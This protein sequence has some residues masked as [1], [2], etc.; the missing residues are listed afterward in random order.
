MLNNL[1]IKALP[2]TD[3][4]V[5]LGGSIRI[6]TLIEL[7]QQHRY[8]LPSDSPEG[9]RELVFKE[10]FED[11]QEYLACFK[12]MNCVMQCPE[13]LERISYEFACDSF[14]DGIRYF[15]VRFA[16][17]L[18]INDR[19]DVTDI[20]MYVNKGLNRAKLEFNAKRSQGEPEYCYGIILCAMRHVPFGVSPY[21]DNVLGMYKS[22]PVK[23]IFSTLA[24]E[25]VH[26]AIKVRDVMGL[27]V[28]GIDIASTERG[29]PASTYREAF[30]VATKN[31]L[32]KTVH[33]GEDY[34]PE[35]IF[36]AI[37]ELHADRIGHGYSLFCGDM[38]S[39]SS[40]TDHTQY[41]DRLSQYIADARITLEVCLTSNMHTMNIGDI[42]NH[43]LAK[44]L[45]N[46]ISVTI[47]TDNRTVS[48]TNINKELRLVVD[49]FGVDVEKLK[50]IIIYGFKR[51]FYPG[52][53][54]EKRKYVSKIIDYFDKIIK[55]HDE[56]NKQ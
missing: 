5:H 43:K 48:N 40:I 45:D 52:S 50:S 31:F 18:Y 30:D 34:G 44:M 20:V 24:L 17:Q 4:H 23:R 33:A 19:Q 56:Y 22:M 47:C 55:E 25:L 3:L 2:K 15:E 37:T 9:M 12:H 6:N 32:K 14:N 28:V 42:K 39:D 1:L 11:L 13:S 53:Y 7:A 29:Y 46:A 27:P 36:Q 10:D 21:F 8:K 51:S 41:V 49:N 26:T 16:P 54:L 38:I 35:S